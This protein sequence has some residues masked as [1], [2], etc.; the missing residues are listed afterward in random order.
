MN[1]T[2]KIK[3]SKI[4]MSETKLVIGL[5][6]V[7][8]GFLDAYTYICRGKVFA[9]AQ[10]G[11]MVL[12]GIHLADGEIETA[13]YYLLPIL[14]F[15]MGV[16]ISDRM[17]M[18]Y[19]KKSHFHWRQWVL[20]IEI[21][22]LTGSIFLPQGNYDTI[23]NTI[24][25]FVCSLQVQSFRKIAGKA[26]ATTMCTGNLRSGTDLLNKYWSTKEKKDFRAAM[27][28]FGIIAE[29]IIGAIIGAF[30]T[31]WFGLPAVLFAVAALLAVFIFL[32]YEEEGKQ[33]MFM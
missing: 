22:A 9:N 14:A 30:L 5:L 32:F 16:V 3:P 10:T 6:A 4:Q 8:G 31:T 12:F 29:F 20:F 15:A 28:Y 13:C 33:K 17:R 2:D 23:A 25:S 11:N 19:N 24:V 21:L 27:H 1:E 26:C 7:A 18:H